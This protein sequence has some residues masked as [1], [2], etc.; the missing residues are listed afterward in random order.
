MATLV[1]DELRWAADQIVNHLDYPSAVLSGIQPDRRHLD[2][3]GFHCSV[4]DLIAHGNGGDYSNTRANDRGFNP[5]YGAAFD[6]SLSKTDM[7]KAY[8][9]VHTVWADKTDP[10]RKYVNAINGWD[11][12]GNATRLDLDVGVVK[13]ASSDHQWHNHAEIHRKYVRDVKAARA[14]VSIYR[15]ESKATWIA[16]EESP[17]TPEEFVMATKDDVKQAV[18]EALEEVR[19][20]QASGPRKRLQEDRPAGQKWSNLSLRALLEYAFEDAVSGSEASAAVLEQFRQE[21]HTLLAQIVADP[22]NT[23]HLDD[24]QVGELAELLA[25][26]MPA[27]AEVARAVNDDAAARLQS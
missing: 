13:Y 17:A 9:R 10:R 12:S 20:Y 8:G 25:A 1:S 16:R 7:I 5:K 4:E 23:V 15:G 26:K 24:T 19:P 3:G 18:I 2:G 27:A 21:T 22:G 6:V 14:V 11:G